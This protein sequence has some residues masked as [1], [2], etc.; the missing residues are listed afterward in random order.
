[1]S[2]DLELKVRN[3]LFKRDITL[4]EFAEELGISQPYLTD[5]LRGRRV[6]PKAQ[7]RVVQIKK[8][9]GV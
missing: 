6:G 5:I 7:E 1:M 8:L 2:R 4:K 3:E 9:L